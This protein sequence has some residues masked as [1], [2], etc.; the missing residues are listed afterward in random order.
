MKNFDRY[1]DP[2]D[3]PE[4]PIC[5]D[6]GQNMKEVFMGEWKCEN[7]YCPSKF[8]SG[9]IEQDM[10]EKICDLLETSENRKIK[11]NVLQNLMNHAQFEHK[12]KIERWNSSKLRDINYAI[13]MMD[14]ALEYADVE[15]TMD[16]I[17]GIRRQWNEARKIL[18]F[19]ENEENR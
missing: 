4:V 12:Q 8:V 5:E 6:C 7:P 10:A 11:I 19:F 14:S 17:M 13:Q 3:E 16:A 18:V 15:P 2:P 9:S 1:Y